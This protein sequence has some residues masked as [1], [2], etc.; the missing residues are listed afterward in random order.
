M[1]LMKDVVQALEPIKAATESLS[2]KSVN[3][4][5][6]DLTLQF[7]LDELRNLT[8]LSTIG[9]QLYDTIENRV[10]QRRNEHVVSMLFYLSKEKP[11]LSEHQSLKYSSKKEIRSN[12]CKTYSRLF[13]SLEQ[14]N[15][16]DSDSDNDDDNDIVE[17]VTE[18]E[19]M[20]AKQRLLSRIDLHKKKE[21]ETVAKSDSLIKD[22]DLLDKTG[23]LSERLQKVKNAL[24]TIRPTSVDAE[25]V[26][27]SSGHFVT[28]KRT[29]LNDASINAI[30]FNK[31]L[32]LNNM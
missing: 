12:L 11:L 23:T 29:R 9:E 25:R 24:L 32:F 27:S 18:T 6:T 1:K 4:I 10:S 14:G 8:S 22:C 26:F 5:T 28:N 17:I 30:I 15:D 31:Y 16:S 2:S 19:T 13:N 3:L 7:V 21:N 20:S